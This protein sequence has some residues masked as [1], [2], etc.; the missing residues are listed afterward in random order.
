MSGT[1]SIP[2]MDR[3][4]TA[5]FRSGWRGFHRLWNSFRADTP[6]PYVT[7]Y[8]KYG[9]KLWLCPTDYIDAFVLLAGY[10]ESEVLEAILR[11]L[12]ADGVLWDVGANFGLHAVTASYLR[13]EARVVCIE[14][15]PLLLGRLCA[16]VRLNNLNVEIVSTALADS[17]GLRY[18]HLADGNPGMTTLKPHAAKQYRARVLC[19]CDTGDGL[20]AT[21][22]LPPPT[23]IK[24]DVEG[25]ELD[26]LRG[27]SVVLRS[28][29]LR[30]VIFEH[31]SK[32]LCDADNELY[33]ILASAGFRIRQLVRNENTSHA[34]DNFIAVRERPYPTSAHDERWALDR[35]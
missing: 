26:V 12:D 24:L 15:S 27:L 16:N 20:V 29:Q 10:Y 4:L 18:L 21:N 7:A 33:R 32:L 1:G 19:S 6:Q 23:V 17:R 22:V 5:Y 30:A 9:V 3:L 25:S 13:P 35:V 2:M 34:A 14:P 31:E 28:N 8:N 11:S